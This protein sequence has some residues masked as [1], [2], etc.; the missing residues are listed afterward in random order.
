MLYG[1]AFVSTKCFVL[2]HCRCGKTSKP[3]RVRDVLTGNTSSCRSCATRKRLAALPADKRRE[4][5]VNASRAAARKPKKVIPADVK[6]VRTI[7]ASAKQRCHNPRCAGYGY[8]GGR[9][10]EFRFPS[11]RDAAEWIVDNIGPRPTSRHSIDRIDNNGHYEPGNLR[12]A[13]RVEQARNK[14][15]YRR[16][17]AGERIRTILAVRTDLTYET[18]R[19]WIKAGL[20]DDQILQRRKYASTGV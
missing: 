2:L 4:L 18:I 10:I 5:A 12:W 16:T 8:Y 14:R 6:V 13:T 19:A 17:E 20:S 3:V 7:M 11:P 1:P 9:G 15:A